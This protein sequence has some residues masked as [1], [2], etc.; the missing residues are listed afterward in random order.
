MGC[1]AAPAAPCALLLPLLLHLAASARPAAGTACA[2]DSDCPYSGAWR[3]CG[4]SKQAENCPAP[5]NAKEGVGACVL[6]GATGR[7]ECHCVPG[8][9]QT[10]TQSRDYAPKQAGTKQWLMIGDSI[11]G[12]C[13]N[14]GSSAIPNGTRDHNIQVISNPGN[15]A[16]VWW[17]AHCL[18]G[19]LS[20]P[21]RKPT[22]WDVIT[23]SEAFHNPTT[24]P[25][26]RCC[27]CR[28]ITS[29][30]TT[31]HATTSASSR[32]STRS[33]WPTSPSAWPTPRRRRR[34]SG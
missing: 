11:H 20:D 28:S 14:A 17:G 33:T 32:T 5:T 24:S 34:S 9:C 27:A 6:P 1:A 16:N 30:C 23:V 18:D 26:T 8:V 21:S 12:G 19:W 3:C 29:A 15:G 10:L 31:W 22:D 2:A 25:L 7:T 13:L 4:A